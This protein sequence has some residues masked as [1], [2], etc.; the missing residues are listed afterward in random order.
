MHN[1]HIQPGDTVWTNY[2]GTLEKHV[3]ISRTAYWFTLENR[4]TISAV[5]SWKN[6]ALFHLHYWSLK[7]YLKG[8]L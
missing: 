5:Y 1:L 2:N 7:R 3:V 8:L 6:L 4:R